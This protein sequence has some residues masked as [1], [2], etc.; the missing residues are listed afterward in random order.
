MPMEPSPGDINIR[1][2]SQDDGNFSK[3]SP[4]KPF[5]MAVMGDFTG[6]MNR[7]V[8]ASLQDRRP[9]RIDR[10]DYETVLAGLSPELH[11]VFEEAGD[12]AVQIRIREPDDFH[13]DRL[14]ETLPV[15]QEL[16][17]TLKDLDDPRRFE[18]AAV[19]IR[20]WAGSEAPR[21]AAED[22]G[23]E[24]VKPTENGL[25]A[26]AGEDG[27]PGI[28]DR[29]IDEVNGDTRMP[30]TIAGRSD[31]DRFLNRIVAPHRVAAEDP[32][33]ASLK[34]VVSE[35]IS[36]MMRKILHHPDFQRLESIWRGVGQL[37]SDLETDEFLSIYLMDVSKTELAVDLAGFEGDAGTGIYRLLVREAAGG[38][39][40]VPWAVVA[41]CYTFGTPE[42]VAVLA[43][44]ARISAMAGAPFLSG[45]DSRLIGCASIVETPDTDDW[46]PEA[47]VYPQDTFQA[48]RKQPEAAYIGLALP[49]FL[50][51]VPYG[52]ETDPTDRFDFEEMGETPAHEDYLWGDAAL[53]CIR[54]LARSFSRDGWDL[55]PDRDLEI[56]GLPLHVYREDGA[57]VAKPCAEVLLTE[58]AAL[59]IMDKGI[60]PLL[61]IKNQDGVRLGR[62]Q[63]LADPP[64]RLAGRWEAHE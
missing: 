24:T 10:D 64:T 32:R 53:F 28:L 36:E 37:V 47:G 29:I 59:R 26:E 22:A 16:R 61:S 57:A 25:P 19:R 7:N 3:P 5:R 50:L 52:K 54:L 6:R 33:Q 30:G 13:P 31:W 44:M 8:A 18:H 27:S 63:S 23:P 62:F 4:D 45:A 56:Q 60:M 34:T 55:R 58:R 14:F 39:G 38:P 43:R 35:M 48:L 49:R 12:A 17:Q 42:D 1:L 15:F 46:T 40:A 21:P 51:R 41:G 20:G 9:V 2:S 11:L